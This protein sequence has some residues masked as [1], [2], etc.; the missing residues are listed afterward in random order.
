MSRKYKLA[1]YIG[2]FQPF[3]NGHKKVI[4]DGL[5]IAD[6]VLVMLGSYNTPR[7]A[8]NPYT[9]LERSKMIEPIFN[10]IN[11]PPGYMNR[12]ITTGIF[13]YT[14]DENK[15]IEQI[16][17]KVALTGYKG[18]EVV[19]LGFNRDESSY[20]LSHFPNWHT[21]FSC[22]H[23][24]YNAPINGTEI[25]DA[26][27]DHPGKFF[28]SHYIDMLPET[29]LNVMKEFASSPVF[30]TIQEEWCFIQDYKKSW[31]SAP[32]PPT[33]VT[34]DA[35]VIQSGHILLGKRK[36]SPGK[37]LWALPG[38]FIEKN[39]RIIDG[40]FRE[41]VEETSIKVPEQVLR[42][43]MTHKEVFDSPARSERGRTITHAYLIELKNEKL[44]RVK[45]ADDF[46]EVEWFTFAEFEQMSFK[47][48]EDHWH[49][50]K[51]MIARSK[52]RK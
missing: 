35:V 17:H 5:E 19:L 28:R 26:F 51:H 33:F 22:E 29:T 39:E 4:E 42:G 18:S 27:F 45:A 30:N 49:L 43:S 8:K 36:F 14:Y 47:M 13:D 12:V 38:G 44:P 46:E 16:Q 32:Y 23:H 2:R 10:P 34:T 9:K 48:Y 21:Y 24:H 20:Y 25:R 40:A 37:G 3:H 52:G 6:R 7:T 31:E 1:V 41:L 11:P 15:W 50:A